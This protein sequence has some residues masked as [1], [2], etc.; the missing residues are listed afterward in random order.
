MT[1]NYFALCKKLDTL[2]PEKLSA[3]REA[4]SDCCGV[5][6][7][8]AWNGEE[9]TD[10]LKCGNCGKICEGITE[11]EWNAQQCE[12]VCDMC[13]DSEGLEVR[14]GWDFCNLCDVGVHPIPFWEWRKEA[15]N[16]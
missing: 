10:D 7:K 15:T 4:V 13:G 2:S 14:R 5:S 16:E 8:F 12:D 11:T 3:Y 1:N 9:I 6:V